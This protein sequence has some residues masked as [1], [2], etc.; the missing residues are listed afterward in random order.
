[1]DLMGARPIRKPLTLSFPL[2]GFVHSPLLVPNTAQ[3]CLLLLFLTDGHTNPT[4]IP[5]F[6]CPPLVSTGQNLTP[7]ASLPS[8]LGGSSEGRHVCMRR[9]GS[10]AKQLVSSMLQHV[11]SAKLPITLWL[12][13]QFCKM[14]L[15]MVPS[16]KGS[17][18]D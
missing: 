5:L 16:L 15:A 10:A 4:Q 12:R 18:K 17:H 3:A 9:L 6:Y 14:G 11:A 7:G 8:C 13:V 2:P 1:M